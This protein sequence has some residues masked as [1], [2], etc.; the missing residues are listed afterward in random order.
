MSRMRRPLRAVGFGC[1][2]VLAAFSYGAQNDQAAAQKTNDSVQEEPYS[3]DT[4]LRLQPAYALWQRYDPNSARYAFRARNARQARSWQRKT[5]KSL[6][7]LLGFQDEPKV[8]LQPRLLE[9][10]DKADYT[11]QKVLIRTTAYTEMPVYILLPKGLP[12]P[13]PV[14]IALHGHG[15]GVKDIVGIRKD[16]SN[17]DEP[18]GY[19]K[20]FAVAL[21]RRGFA[22]AAPEISCFGERQTDFSYLNKELGQGAPKTCAHTAALASHLV[23]SALG[24]RVLDTK[25]LVDYLQTRP[26]VDA[27][28]LGMMGISGGGMLTFFTTA[29]DERIKACVVSGYFCTFRDSV[30]AMAHC[31]C[32]YVHG[33]SQFGEMSDIVG[34]IAPRPMLVEAGSLDPIFPIDNVKASVRRAEQVYKV[35]DAEDHIET[36]YFEGKHQI[37][38]KRAYDFLMEKLT[39]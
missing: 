23:G 19:Q 20:D 24:L 35:L 26:D 39:K 1:V 22:V 28:R 36:D 15:Y 6:N 17:R 33:L 9:D 8:D 27:S 38:G 12:R 21:C 37:S 25:R 29:L 14:V 11:R 32:N 3:S 2:A 16:G 18:E 4:K 30:L 34:L 10:V 7:E 13:L 5:R 31:Q